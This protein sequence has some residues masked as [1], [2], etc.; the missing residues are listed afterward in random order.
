MTSN[1]MS[2]KK[3]E[4]ENLIFPIIKVVY[5]YDFK[6]PCISITKP[7]FV[8][9]VRL[10]FGCIICGPFCLFSHLYVAFNNNERA[11]ISYA[12]TFFLLL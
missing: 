11:L 2:D 10:T 5:H 7:V 1:T 9:L 12:S 4:K 8:T 6:I 3:F